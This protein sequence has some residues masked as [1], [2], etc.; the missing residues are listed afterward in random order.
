MPTL[1]AVARDTVSMTEVTEHS[2]EIS[3]LKSTE[4]TDEC[5]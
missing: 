5:G 1:F 2:R 3:Y 4:L